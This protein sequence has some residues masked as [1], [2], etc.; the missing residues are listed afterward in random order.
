MKDTCADADL[1]DLW[2]SGETRRW[3]CNAV[4]ARVGQ[5]LADH[6]G[7]CAQMVLAL[8]PDA[9]RNLIWAALHHDVGEY[10]TGDL[11]WTFKDGGP[12]D[13]IMA[14]AAA[15]A[16]ALADICGRP[17]PPLSAADG[18]RLKLVDRLE[19]LLFVRIHLPQEYAR[20]GSGW[21][22]AEARI[23]VSAVTLVVEDRL[24]AALEKLAR[25]AW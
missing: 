22:E 12:V 13:V 19:A 6:Q 5:T 1:L 16:Q 9:S 4:V 20:Q 7:R 8:W 11:S 17:M 21:R 10:R 2:L 25:G 14:H 23:L 3:H 15:E 24:R 18:L